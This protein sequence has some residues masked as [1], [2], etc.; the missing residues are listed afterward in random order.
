MDCYIGVSGTLLDCDGRLWTEYHFFHG[1][2]KG[3]SPVGRAILAGAAAPHAK[4][5]AGLA[6]PREIS[7]TISN[8]QFRLCSALDGWKSRSSPPS[9]SLRRKM[10]AREP[11]T[12]A[13][14]SGVFRFR[15]RN[16]YT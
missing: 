11:P 4:A 2:N 9:P 12:G 6:G 8:D 14:Q 13:R 10:N 3:S 1:G 7:G 5:C 15:L 16:R